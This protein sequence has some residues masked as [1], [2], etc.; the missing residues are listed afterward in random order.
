MASPHVARPHSVGGVAP[1]SPESTGS[2]TLAPAQRSS[3]ALGEAAEFAAGSHSADSAGAAALLD[4]GVGIDAAGVAAAAHRAGI[5]SDRRGFPAT[6]TGAELREFL[7][8]HGRGDTP[9]GALLSRAAATE[10]AQRLLDRG[11]LLALS[12]STTFDASVSALYRFFTD[13]P[14]HPSAAAAARVAA[15]PPTASPPGDAASAASY[16]S[17]STAGAA[18]RSWRATRI[19][20]TAS[21]LSPPR[22]DDA[23][24]PSKVS[25][26]EQAEQARASGLTSAALASPQRPLAGVMEVGRSAAEQSEV[27]DGRREVAPG[28]P[29]SRHGADH[30][31]PAARP[32]A[33]LSPIG[34]GRRSTSRDSAS[35]ASHAL[36]G[37]GGG[38]AAH[39]IGGVD[40]AHAQESSET[41]AAAAAAAQ[42]LFGGGGAG[43]MAGMH[44][45]SAPASRA[46]LGSSFAPAVTVAVPSVDTR[47]DGHG[48]YS[49]YQVSVRAGTRRWTVWRR[50][51][52][53]RALHMALSEEFPN[54]KLPS[55]PPKK[56]LGTMA[57]EFVETRR[58]QLQAYAR[59]LVAIP[60]VWRSNEVVTFLDDTVN[61][62]SVQI[63]LQRMSGRVRTVE[64]VAAEAARQLRRYDTL[65][66]QHLANERAMARRIESLEA[67]LAHLV[68]PGFAAGAH[69]GGHAGAAAAAVA[70][71]GAG[72]LNSS[73]S[74]GVASVTAAYSGRAS[75]G[76]SGSGHGFVSPLAASS[77]RSA[78]T[79]RVTRH[80]GGAG[81][82]A[83]V[84]APAAARSMG[85]LGG[86]VAAVLPQNH[87]PGHAVV[88]PAVPMVSAAAASVAVSAAGA[89][90]PA[91]IGHSIASPGV[92]VT[93]T[94]FS[95]ASAA[96]VE[97][98]ASVADMVVTRGPATPLDHY[99]DRLLVAL[100]PSRAAAAQ[101]G[102]V[103]RFMSDMLK[104]SLGAHT[105]AIGAGAARCWL[106]GDP[107]R[108]CAFLCRGQ[109]ATWCARVA[110][111]ACRALARSA[112]AS[113]SPD[114][115]ARRGSGSSTGNARG[116]AP[117]GGTAAGHGGFALSDDSA[118]SWA[119]TE[120]RRSSDEA[121]GAALEGDAGS[122]AHRHGSVPV[123][124]VR[125]V[126]V[127]NHS[128]GG[129][130]AAAAAPRGPSAGNNPAASDGGAPS[131]AADLRRRVLCLVD[132]INVEISANALGE[133]CVA[134]L[135][136]AVDVAV[137]RAHLFKRSLL[138]ARAWACGASDVIDA[139]DGGSGDD[140][141]GGDA[142]GSGGSGGRRPSGDDAAGDDVG[143]GAGPL[144]WRALVNLMLWVFARRSSAL[145]HPIQAL[146]WL[147]S[148]AAAVDWDRLAVGAFGATARDTVRDVASATLREAEA[149]AEASQGVASP[150]RSAGGVE[151]AEVWAASTELP[152]LGPDAAVSASHAAAVLPPATLVRLRQRCA[153]A[154]RMRRGQAVAGVSPPSAG[155]GVGGLSDSAGA[156][157]EVP[158][159]ARLW[160]VDV[161]EPTRDAA[162]DASPTQRARARRLFVA[163]ALRLRPCLR[164]AR[165]GDWSKA[166][167]ALDECLHGVRS[168]ISTPLMR[169]GSGGGHESSSVGAAVGGFLAGDAAAAEA[170]VE[171]CGL[172]L[173]AEVTAPALLALTSEILARRGRLP[174]GEIGK[175]LQ[176]A[177]SN[178]ALSGALKERF[179]GLKKFLE[180][181][182]DHFV[183][184]RSHRFNPLVYLRASLDE[185]DVRRVREGGVPHGSAG[186]PAGNGSAGGGAGA[187]HAGV[188][189]GNGGKADGTASG[190]AAHGDAPHPQHSGGD[191]GGRRR[192]AR[193]KRGGGGGHG[194]NSSAD[195]GGSGTQAG[196]P[197]PSLKA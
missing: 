93:G 103:R 69:P 180:S 114:G 163:G 191:A 19:A 146:V 22:G 56:F 47:D 99:V 102:R 34:S 140:G 91:G 42:M 49:S 6:V 39:D 27:A 174:V 35:G 14:G 41:A 195:P 190:A 88:P 55:M 141:A 162:A 72:A 80:A 31:D 147:L 111:A 40:D 57:P 46:E 142:Q 183:L 156:L 179:G 38:I 125:A 17:S 149:E 29:P 5:V 62:L 26:A 138:L 133:L 126:N 160:V 164:A 132:G 43:G 61:S 12:G 65:L 50:Y 109:E 54:V 148:D 159:G 23:Y 152:N 101:H 173:D 96:A 8:S 64:S 168:L 161:L 130:G 84:H 59:A 48:P 188:G 73:A 139:S 137:G 77:V 150:L 178:P 151:R 60:A 181:F 193:R 78:P 70:A 82:S 107:E 100:A 176:E 37:G 115:R 131:A 66:R 4:A 158:L 129:M 116:A 7:R 136:E 108:L 9:Q 10:H 145:H 144:P 143:D 63:A 122:A 172:L 81:S 124:N 3:I 36:R 13:V 135:V 134:A 112:S 166:T 44:A 75:H 51:R 68:A 186:G 192:K 18:S 30:A 32:G 74:L 67:A 170:S 97:L 128:D 185:A 95:V 33:A 104:R 167:A 90:I 2:P 113:S 121:A 169:E 92:A 105:L 94:K 120:R 187:H 165:L 106:P 86:G 117:D 28:S 123:C 1:R 119:D 16:A 15:T 171:Y 197:S 194:P 184:G 189:V 182:P 79:S 175:L 154:A 52:E 157:S 24:V 58:A 76:S 83:P 110:D 98:A 45:S 21:G 71:M 177:T 25:R 196:K 153:K 155:S 127:V 53:F 11:A 20:R 87:H 118:G 89:A 85:V